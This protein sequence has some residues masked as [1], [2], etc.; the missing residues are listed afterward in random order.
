MQTQNSSFRFQVTSFANCLSKEGTSI[1]IYNW[2]P[3]IKGNTYKEAIEN[4]R[5]FTEAGED[6][7]AA[8][9]KRRLPAICP[10]GVLTKGRKADS[11][12]QRN[13]IGWADYDRHDLKWAEAARDSLKGMPGILGAY[14]TA[15]YG[16]HVFYKIPDGMNEEDTHLYT[17]VV[18]Q[19]LDKYLDCP[20]DKQVENN[21]HLCSVSYDPGMFY[22]MPDKVTDFPV[23]KELLENQ[24]KLYEKLEQ[25][26]KE[27]PEDS[28]SD[29]DCSLEEELDEAFNNLFRQEQHAFS[30]A[31]IDDMLTRY[32]SYNPLTSGNRNRNLLKLG[33]RAFYKRFTR[34]E[35]EYLVY[36]VHC[37]IGCE[38]YTQNR[39]RVCLSWGYT[40]CDK[41]E[42]CK[43]TD[44]EAIQG[45]TGGE[46]TR[47]SQKSQKS[48]PQR[49]IFEEPIKLSDSQG[50]YSRVVE[51]CC[52]YL[53]DS[54]YD[55]LPPFF[56]KLGKRLRD[57][58]LLIKK[59][60]L[61]MIASPLILSPH[62]G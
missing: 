14:V 38:E 23:E 2:F 61:M 60:G 8:E 12:L 6:S 47:K 3:L 59:K 26:A 25:T 35:L 49:D 52:P 44:S 16:L 9:I 22:T 20:H 18:V 34:D 62:I 43:T 5:K 30:K 48:H 55:N 42:I 36:A 13:G 28:L 1:N 53:P 32:I 57:F 50:D 21:V 58:I 27:K 46:Y 45:N 39:I 51:R 41:Q 33:Q 24:R 29:E 10:C 4:I 31:Q 15:R 17:S 37:L 19:A 7:K 56:K 11:P 40:H 54:V